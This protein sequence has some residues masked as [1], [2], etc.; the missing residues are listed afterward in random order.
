VTT[1]NLP[2]S[3]TS[4]LAG[5]H[6]LLAGARGFLGGHFRAALGQAGAVVTSLDNDCLGQF[7]RHSGDICDPKAFEQI[8]SELR[9]IVHSAGIA[10]PVHYQRLPL[11]AFDVSTVGTRN[12]LELAEKTGA[13]LLY[14]S[15][16]EIYGDPDPRHIPTPESYR[17]NVSCTGDRSCYDESKRAGETLCRIFHE[18]GVST[19]TVRPFNFVGPGMRDDDYRVLPNIRNSLRLGTPIRVYGTGQQTRTFCHVT[20]GIR[21]CLQALVHGVPGQAYNIGSPGPEVTMRALADKCCQISG[22]EREIQL[23]EHPDSYPSDEPQRRCP[24][25]TKARQHL[26][27]EPSVELD[28]MLE[29]FLS[30]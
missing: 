21:G 7:P 15:S 8:G 18:R 2:A 24:D 28:A 11:Q 4:A 23:I 3:V 16:S 29:E 30:A 10:S 26:G 25:I 22:I 6:V 14:L 1:Y 13:R 12:L 17:G 27:Y 5:A 19:V 9:Y 20:D